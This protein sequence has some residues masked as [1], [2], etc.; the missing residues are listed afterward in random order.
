M[1]LENSEEKNPSIAN[2]ELIPIT[3]KEFTGWY[4]LCAANG[5]Y[6]GGP[7]GGEFFLFYST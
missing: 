2:E 7:I 3:K 1:N 6:G 4:I 5:I